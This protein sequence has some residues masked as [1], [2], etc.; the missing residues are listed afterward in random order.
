MALSIPVKTLDGG[1]STQLHAETA[2]LSGSEGGREGGGGEG[3]R[4]KGVRGGGGVAVCVYPHACNLNLQPLFVISSGS[5]GSFCFPLEPA[6][7]PHHFHGNDHT[8]LAAKA[9]ASH[10]SHVS[11]GRPPVS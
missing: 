6:H 1:T 8:G 3:E 7:Q 2:I 9:C 11:G 10:F 4:G 5:L